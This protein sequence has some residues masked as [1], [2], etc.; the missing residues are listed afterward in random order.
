V[1]SKDSLQATLANSS[2][3]EEE[4]EESDGGRAPVRGGIPRPHRHGPRRW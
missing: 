4:E 3:E 1:S 2:S